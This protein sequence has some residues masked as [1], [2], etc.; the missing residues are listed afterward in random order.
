MTLLEMNKLWISDAPAKPS[1][2]FAVTN[3]GSDF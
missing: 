2:T 3:K 1:L